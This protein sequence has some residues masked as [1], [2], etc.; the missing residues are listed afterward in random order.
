MPPSAER[1]MRAA[2]HEEDFDAVGV[3]LDPDRTIAERGLEVALPGVA[4]LE[5][6]TVRVD[7][8][9]LRRGRVRCHSVRRITARGTPAS[10]SP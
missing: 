2:V 6:V 3:A 5:D 1:E 9:H 4:R 10:A 8:R 7:G